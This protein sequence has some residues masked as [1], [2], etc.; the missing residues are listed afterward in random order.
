M[1]LSLGFEWRP[2]I[3][4]SLYSGLACR[5]LARRNYSLLGVELDDTAA[6]LTS[7]ADQIV[8]IP[9]DATDPVAAAEIVTTV[10]QQ[11]GPITLLIN[12]AWACYAELRR[13]ATTRG[14]ISAEESRARCSTSSSPIR[15]S[16]KR[17]GSFI[18]QYGVTSSPRCSDLHPSAVPQA[19]AMKAS[20]ER[21]KCSGLCRGAKWLT[22]GRTISS[23]SGI[24][25]ARY[26]ACSSLMNSSS[27]P[28]T[29]ATGTATSANCRAE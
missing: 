10:E 9:D 7:A 14:R 20:I 5:R 19:L 23:A 26:S 1:D 25:R 15:N 17:E 4:S 13:S 12:D 27:S 11:L 3:S 18:R 29:M 6:Q 8:A 22:P 16:D 2:L 28:W 24:L 21:L